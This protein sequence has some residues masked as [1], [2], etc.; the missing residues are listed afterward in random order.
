MSYDLYITS[1]K[2]SLDDFSAYFASNARYKVENRQAFYSNDETGVYFSFDHNSEEPQE[3]DDI[4]H[5]VAFNINYYRPHY[6]AL[7]AEPEVGRFIEH[8]NCAIRDVQN[9]GMENGPYS[10]EGFLRGWN[11][12]N[13]FGYHA[14][15]ACDDS[16]G[17]IYSR[18][19]ADLERIWRWNTVKEQR[20]AAF[21][22]DIFVPRIMF[23]TFD[24]SLGSVCVWPDG[25][26]TLIPQVDFLYLPRKELAP[27]KLF[28]TQEEDFCVVPRKD[29]PEFFDYYATEDFEV[30]S[31]KLPAP[32]TPQ[33]VKDYVKK[34]KPFTGEVAR[35]GFDS[36]L[37]A[38]LVSKC[39]R[40][41]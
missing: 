7:E 40:T 39:K 9:S 22:E 21:K 18:P 13:E 27:K 12:G 17:P 19:T 32:D 35:I 2:I 11:A 25:I 16:H 41:D 8:F 15:L 38:E 28:K 3:E 24:G 31:F 26:S 36:V 1:P 14:I 29:F 34:L 23:M 37:N 33:I 30:K 10:R 6:F 4:E 5:S 20:Q